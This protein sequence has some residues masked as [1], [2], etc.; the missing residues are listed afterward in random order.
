MGRP[1]RIA[2]AILVLLILGAVALAIYA[3]T[4]P[5]PH[6]HYEETIANTRFSG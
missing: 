5:P 3:G 4:I 1:A 2:V 6:Q